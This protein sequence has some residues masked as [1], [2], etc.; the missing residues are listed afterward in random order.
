MRV[1]NRQTI[2]QAR[3]CHE[4]L[5]IIAIKQN[6]GK[7]GNLFAQGKTRQR[8]ITRLAQPN[9]PACKQLQ[10]RGIPSQGLGETIESWLPITTLTYLIATLLHKRPESA[11]KI[12]VQSLNHQHDIQIARCPRLLTCFV[13]K[14]CGGHTTNQYIIARILREMCLELI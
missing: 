6:R 11:A 5:V 3:I 12:R 14:K 2:K 13:Q 8:E 4:K 9:V 7:T 1:G 10:H